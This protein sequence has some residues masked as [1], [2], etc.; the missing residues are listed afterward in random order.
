MAKVL[1]IAPNTRSLVDNR[2]DLIKQIEKRGNEV[3]ALIPENEYDE[4]KLKQLGV[5][6]YLYYMSRQSMNPFN[7]IASLFDLHR[8]IK[9]TNPDCV[10][11]YHIK[12]VVYGSI[13]AKLAG[14]DNLYAMVT[15]LG[16]LFIGD[17]FKKKV[18]QRIAL[19]MYRA[20]L[21]LN[22]KVFIQNYNDINFFKEKN[23]VNDSK[24][25]KVNG[26][27]VNTDFYYPDYDY[28]QGPV[29]LMIS[30]L[31]EDKGVY[32]YAA[33]AKKLKEQG[34]EAD[35]NLLGPYDDNPSAIDKCEVEDWVEEGYIN[36]L[37]KTDDVRPYITSA[38][39]IVLPSYR[40][41]TPRSVLEGMSMARPII[42][43]RAPGCSETVE[44]GE[45][46]FLVQT[47]DVDSLVQAMKR[48]VNNTGLIEEMGEKSR[49][50]AEEK[51]DVDKVN[52][53]IIEN[54][55]L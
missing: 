55:D 26:S 25:I 7:D 9:K 37:G 12:S 18:L 47:R 51:Y 17:N 46:G 2:G 39:I 53:T 36:Y 4:G 15:G 16:Y 21:Y 45:N 13:A 24:I 43:T 11:S 52:E 49:K 29:F 50:I 31:L 22:K 20:G 38:D 48:F 3:I 19:M 42:T 28:P 27:G 23:V 10:F 35:F 6:H 32:E 1:F 8:Q 14:I 5:K 34:C 44:E 41:G 30:R 54:M 40:E 33:A